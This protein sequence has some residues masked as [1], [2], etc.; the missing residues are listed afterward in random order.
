VK[1]AVQ[2]Y[3]GSNYPN[4][5]QSVH[6]RYVPEDNSVIITTPSKSLAGELTL[7]TRELRAHLVAH[8]VKAG[9]IIAR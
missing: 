8:R 7:N 3:V 2:E 9:R 1:R 6:V 5:V 4:A